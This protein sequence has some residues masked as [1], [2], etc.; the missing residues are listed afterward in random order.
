M[1]M[2]LSKLVGNDELANAGKLTGIRLRDSRKKMVYVGAVL[3]ALLALQMASTIKSVFDSFAGELHAWEY[4]MVDISAFPVVF[5]A[6]AFGAIAFMYRYNYQSYAMYPLTTNSRFL[7]AQAV[8]HI[9]LLFFAVVTLVCYLV[10]YGVFSFLSA[11]YDSVFLAYQFS[12]SYVVA[13]FFVSVLYVA[14]VMA[15]VSLIAALLRKIGIYGAVGLI[16]VVIIG[17]TNLPTVSWIFSNMAGFLIHEQSVGWFLVKGFATWLILFGSAF[18]I[19]KFTV[20]YR[21][22]WNVSSTKAVIAAAVVVFLAVL[23]AGAMYFMVML[24]QEGDD[25]VFREETDIVSIDGGYLR[26]GQPQEIIIDGSHIPE[27]SSIRLKAYDSNRRIMTLENQTVYFTNYDFIDLSGDLE[28][29]SVFTGQRI[30][31]TYA[32]PF[33]EI[34]GVDLYQFVKPEFSARLEGNTL[35][36]DYQY[37]DHT[38]VIFITVWEY[39]AQFD[40]YKEKMG[41]SKESMWASQHSS[42]RGW[43]HISVE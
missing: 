40:G 10:Q 31:V 23:G 11:R 3:A 19:N 5:I 24:V 28:S 43:I 17:L 16:V 29:L 1:G 35:Y 26:E 42:G 7:A 4:Q 21:N 9:W 39:M 32:L 6:A 8:Y 41:I 38:S 36:L 12:W 22:E 13:G 27:G 37:A 18:L 33:Y 14:I 34:N 25:G 30:I 2:F 20:F 15:A